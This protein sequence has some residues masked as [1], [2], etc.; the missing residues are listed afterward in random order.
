M[1][2]GP[3]YEYDGIIEGPNIIDELQLHVEYFQV[4]ILLIVRGFQ[5]LEELRLD[6]GHGSVIQQRVT[7]FF[8]VHDATIEQFESGDHVDDSV[9]MLGLRLHRIV[10]IGQIGQHWTLE[11]G[12]DGFDA[13]QLIVMQ[14]QHFQLIQVL[15]AGPVGQ[16][17]DVIV[18]EVQSDQ[19]DAFREEL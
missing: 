14:L 8:N 10:V 17:G 9:F 2:P 5:I 15:E 18:G 4:E 16:P 12:L 1:S 3:L 7:P 19:V 11:D 13:S 6:K